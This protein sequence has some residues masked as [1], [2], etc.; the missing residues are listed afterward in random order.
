MLENSRCVIIYRSRENM[1]RRKVRYVMQY[2]SYY[3]SPLGKMLLAADEI[4][5]TGVWFDEQKYLPVVW[6]KHMKRKRF[7]CL[8][9]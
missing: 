3:D 1:C 8:R 7:R 2:I 4:G 5:L 9:M 6:M